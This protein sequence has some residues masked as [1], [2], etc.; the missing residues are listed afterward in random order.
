MTKTILV[1]DDN[2]EFLEFMTDFLTGEGYDVVSH[3]D[4]HTALDV[5]RGACPQLLIVD[6]AMPG[7]TGWSIIEEMQSDQELDGIPVIVCTA[8]VTEVGK[9]EHFAVDRDIRTILKPFAV[10]ELLSTIEELTEVKP[11]A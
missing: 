3:Y 5:L 7:R 4:P 11:K 2:R 9:S 1:I 10:D 6:I 8:A